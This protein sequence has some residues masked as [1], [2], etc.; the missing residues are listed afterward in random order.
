MPT[1]PG[2]IVENGAAQ[3]TKPMCRIMNTESSPTDKDAL[4]KFM[5]RLGQAYLACG[6]QTALVE[7]Y[8]RRIASAHGMRQARVVAF[9]TAL[10]ITVQD[11]NEER[12]TLAESPTQVL[13]PGRLPGRRGRE[14][15][16]T[17]TSRCRLP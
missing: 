3:D 2:M 14:S 10:F 16:E 12:V 8:L 13:R 5:L 7:L 4:L 11:H 17:Q 1:S 6:E 9:S 15:A